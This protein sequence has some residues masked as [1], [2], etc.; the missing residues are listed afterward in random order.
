MINLANCYENQQHFQK[1]VIWYDFALSVYPES[2]DS[3]YGIALCCFK[4]GDPSKAYKHIKEAINIVKHLPTFMEEKIHLVY[5]KAMCLKMLKKYKESE[6]AYV[7]MNKSFNREEGNKIA[8]YIFGMILMPLETNRKVS[9]ATITMFLE[10][11]GI[12]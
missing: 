6:N 9:K 10:N 12:C 3:H 7:S 8:K 5:M 1:A 4:D 2:D 11:H